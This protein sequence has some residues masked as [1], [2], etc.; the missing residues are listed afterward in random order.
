MSAIAP[1]TDLLLLKSP[2]ELDMNNQLTFENKT[3]QASYFSSL[4]HLTVQDI[5]YQRKDGII[6]YPAHIDSLLGYNYVM[7][8]NENYT[9]KWFYAFI[10]NMEYLNDNC[11]AIYIKTDPYQTYMFEMD[12]KRSF[13]EREHV[14]DDTIGLHTLDEEINCG[15]YV[16]PKRQD[17]S[18]F[19]GLNDT[20]IVAQVTY[21]FPEMQNAYGNRKRIY[22]G[23]PNGAFLIA[24]DTETPQSL[25][26]F[27]K[28]YATAGK[29]DAILSMFLMPKDMI[30][31][32]LIT[33]SWNITVDGQQFSFDGYGL[34]DTLDAFGFGSFTW[35]KAETLNGYIPRNNKLYTYPYSYLMLTN[36]GG[37]TLTYHWEDFVNGEAKFELYGIPSQACTFKLTPI[38]YK[39]RTSY[40]GGWMWSI[41]GQKLPVISWLSDYYLNWQAKNGTNSVLRSANNFERRLNT[42]REDKSDLGAFKNL[43]GVLATG[44]SIASSTLNA[45][46]NK[47]TG[48]TFQ[49]SE[50]PDQSEG[51][52]YTGDLNF[53]MN[54]SSF[55]GYSMTVR[56]EVAKVIDEYFDMFGYKINR[57]KRPN[58]T[59]R[60]NWNYVKTIDANIE[61]DIPQMYLQEIKSMFND[62][63]TLWHNPSTFLS[64]SQSNPIV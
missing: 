61:G 9:N 11:T 44:A 18:Y 42:E 46:K 62:G 12:F 34:P 7:Y 21:L 45:I 17:F 41:N 1:S 8:K 5:S 57:V 37:E 32:N 25:S 28:M 38:G 40:V 10:T 43:A 30:G 49:A 16:A 3:A 6:R 4:P 51:N 63:V 33:F 36:N 48:A 35:T 59:G 23:L 27:L 60:Q 50:T 31:G 39:G 24:V 54:K 26:N 13:V 58:L 55:S 20:M 14:N 53:A 22:G 47:V 56:A 2:I 15:E 19:S 52:A 29:T 64:Y